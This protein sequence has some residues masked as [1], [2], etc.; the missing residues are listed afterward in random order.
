MTSDEINKI[1][2]GI[3]FDPIVSLNTINNNAIILLFIISDDLYNHELIDEI[4]NVVRTTEIELLIDMKVDQLVLPLIDTKENGEQKCKCM[5]KA[6][7]ETIV[8]FELLHKTSLSS[9]LLQHLRRRL[10]T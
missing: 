4:E 2:R 5:F 10:L 6:L 3:K 1:F 9:I 7:I 8:K